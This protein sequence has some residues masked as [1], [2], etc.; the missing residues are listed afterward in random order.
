M[1][2]SNVYIQETT[3]GF[4]EYRPSSV[5]RWLIPLLAR[6]ATDWVCH[7]PSFLVMTFPKEEKLLISPPLPF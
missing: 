3:N 2:G 5:R 4:A 1:G 7:G 6:S